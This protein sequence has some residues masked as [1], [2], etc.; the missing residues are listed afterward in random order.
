[1]EFICPLCNRPISFYNAIRVDGWAYVCQQC[2]MTMNGY[3]I[4][5]RLYN[6]APYYTNFNKENNICEK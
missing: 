5:R 3:D 2:S 1:M 4:R 6:T